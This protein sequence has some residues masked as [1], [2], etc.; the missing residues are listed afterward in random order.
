MLLSADTLQEQS[1]L[2]SPRSLPRKTRLPLFGGKCEKGKQVIRNESI[3]ERSALT[4]T[5][6]F[7][8][9][10]RKRSVVSGNGTSTS[11][12]ICIGT[13][14]RYHTCNTQVNQRDT[15][16]RLDVYAFVSCPASV[17]D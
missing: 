16:G 9:L 5:I 6:C 10:L 17:I 13:Y 12:P 4:R 3:S 14:K 11:R 8:R 15:R 1:A 7:R 2:L